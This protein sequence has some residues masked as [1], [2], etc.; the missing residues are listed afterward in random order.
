MKLRLVKND[1]TVD[2]GFIL[3]HFKNRLKFWAFIVFIFV[4]ITMLFDLLP[5]MSY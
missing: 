4:S 1:D 3:R 5:V 2:D